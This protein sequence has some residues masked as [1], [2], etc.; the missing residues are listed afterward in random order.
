[1]KTLYP[2][3]AQPSPQLA[4]DLDEA[5][6]ATEAHPYADAR[7]E[8]ARVC[9]QLAWALAPHAARTVVREGLETRLADSLETALKLAEGLVYL[10]PADPTPP[11][12]PEPVEGFPHP[13]RPELVEGRFR[14]R[15]AR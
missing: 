11:V 6:R 8:R 3:Y 9:G 13:V 15:R 4:L 2:A 5:R 12:R 7:L 10:D 1:M 14:V